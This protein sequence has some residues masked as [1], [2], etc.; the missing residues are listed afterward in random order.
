[1]VRKEY[2]GEKVLKE[3]EDALQ[4]FH[5]HQNIFKDAGVRKGFDLPWQHALVHYIELIQLFGAPNGLCTSIT[6]NSHIRF[7][8]EPWRCSNRNDPLE[9]MLKTNTCLSKLAAGHQN[10][11]GRGMLNDPIVPGKFFVD[12]GTLVLMGSKVLWI[13]RD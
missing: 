9:Q 2:I 5:K 6:E 10:F 8:K 3:L 4:N 13:V 11:V 1:M 7:V 12:Q